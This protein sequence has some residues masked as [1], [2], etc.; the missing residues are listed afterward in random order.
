MGRD[1]GADLLG[2]SL[3]NGMHLSSWWLKKHPHVFLKDVIHRAWGNGSSVNLLI[4]QA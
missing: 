2:K 4:T 3:L 1:G